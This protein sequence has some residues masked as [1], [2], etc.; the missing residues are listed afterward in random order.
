MDNFDKPFPALAI[1]KRKLVAGK[2]LLKSLIY[3]FAIF[4]LLFILLLMI[5]T[6]LLRQDT[7]PAGD[8]PDKGILT[9]DFNNDYP[10]VRADDLFSELS[11]VPS[12]S[13]FDLIKAINVAALDDR[14]KAIVANVNESSLGLS[15]IQEVRRAIENFRKTGKKAYLY[16]TGFGSFGGGTSE[17]YLAAA[18]DE[19]WMQPNTEAGITGLNFEVPF[20]RSILSKAGVQAEFY[21]RYEYKNAAASLLND[22][23]SPEY[24][25]ELNKLGGSIY[26]V[27]KEDICRDRN[28]K[29]EMFD[30]LVN[31]APLSAE[32]ALAAGLI[33]YIGYKPELIEKA[34]QETKGKMVNVLDY[35][36]SF[37]S[38]Y[39]NLPTV[40]LVVI[41]G[42]IAEGESYA[43]SLRDEAVAGADTIVK[44]LDDILR[45]DNVKA[46]VIR[47]NSPG[48]SYTASNEIWYAIKRI[49]EKKQIP[50]VVTQ[51]N[52]AASGGYFV[53]I[54]GDYI[55]SEPSS[56]TGS[57]GVLGGKMVLS[58]L[59]N[60]LGIHWGEVKFGENS[61]ILSVNHKFTPKEKEI[62]N[63]SLDRVY[64][65]FT[66]KVSEARHIEITKMDKLARGRVWTGIDAA[67]A[68]LVD[69][70]GGIDEAV[71]WAKAQAGIKPKDKFEIVYYP[72][73]KTLSEK[74]SQLVSGNPKISVNKIMNDLG[75][76]M[77]D[78]NMLNRMKYDL[79]L[80]PLK[81]SM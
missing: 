28:L 9:I 34:I 57:I 50:V 31:N 4:G 21:T 43:N 67:D 2:I 22:K 38:G 5:V 11:E 17:Y 36:S 13:F 37:S 69:A 61:G 16:S 1:R 25:K 19:I 68:G 24:R 12:T 35:V 15:Q 74:L 58:G 80:P 78:I 56:I 3:A 7:I 42:V 49:K 72:K 47:V 79:I 76:E 41:E 75:I 70:I 53:S 60:K 63:C 65:D 64:K 29:K 44:Q 71:A 26:S 27:M 45:N 51:G 18:F 46:L 55:F 77:N 10:E 52:Y 66:L 30:K 23:L 8:V 62:F 14:I 32:D 59:W 20:F 54:A 73:K 39:R 6:A 33:D 40:A 81:I 48:G